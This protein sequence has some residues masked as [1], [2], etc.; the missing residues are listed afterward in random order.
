MRLLRYLR[1]AGFGWKH[2]V[3]TIEYALRL[4]GELQ[5]RK[6]A[7]LVAVSM[8]ADDK[9]AELMTTTLLRAQ[10]CEELGMA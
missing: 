10:F 1:S 9:P 2:E 7:S 5:S 4:L 3:S 6:W 8:I